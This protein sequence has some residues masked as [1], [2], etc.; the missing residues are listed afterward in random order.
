MMIISCYSVATLR[1]FLVGCLPES[2]G[3]LSCEVRALVPVRLNASA[4]LVFVLEWLGLR[5]STKVTGH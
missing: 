1:P 5:R 4:I 2:W 3:S